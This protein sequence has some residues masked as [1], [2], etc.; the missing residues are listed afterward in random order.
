MHSRS[1]VVGLLLAGCCGR[2]VF[3]SGGI[4]IHEASVLLVILNGMR[5]L[6]DNPR[7]H[8]EAQR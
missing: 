6:R 4:L 8:A 3:L 5:L 1:I 7:S 2:I